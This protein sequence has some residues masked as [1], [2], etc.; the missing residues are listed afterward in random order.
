MFPSYNEYNIG[1]LPLLKRG[2]RP[3]F[4]TTASQPSTDPPQGENHVEKYSHRL[5]RATDDRQAAP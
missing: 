5:Y 3:I 1:T 4:I 2:Q